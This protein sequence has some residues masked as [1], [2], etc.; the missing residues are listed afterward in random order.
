MRILGN[1]IF[2]LGILFGILMALVIAGGG[3]LPVKTYI[4][5]VALLRA[6]WL[7]RKAPQRR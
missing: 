5:A 2:I 4:L 7:F 6:G 1:I 3:H